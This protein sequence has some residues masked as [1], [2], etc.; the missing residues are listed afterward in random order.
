METPFGW[1]LCHVE[2]SQLICKANRLTGPYMVR[3][4]TGDISEQ[5]KVQFHSRKQPAESV[6]LFLY[7]WRF[8]FWRKCRRQPV[9]L[10]QSSFVGIFMLFICTYFTGASF[11]DCFHCVWFLVNLSTKEEFNCG[12]FFED[13]LHNLQNFNWFLFVLQHYSNFCFITNWFIF[14]RYLVN[15]VSHFVFSVL[16]I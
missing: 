13:F 7:L 3:V 14:S 5:T 10:F 9:V 1:G 6:L 8:Q 12:R 16:L 15:L 4:F 11:D 2:T